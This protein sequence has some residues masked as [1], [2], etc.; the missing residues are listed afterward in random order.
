MARENKRGY[1]NAPNKD[2]P[3]NDRDPGEIAA[4]AVEQLRAYQERAAN[5]PVAR[6]THGKEHDAGWC[7]TVCNP[8][9]TLWFINDPS[10]GIYSYTVEEIQTLK[11]AHIR[12]VH[13]G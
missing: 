12:Q 7:C 5:W 4:V 3:L 1:Y 11:V 9:Q 2:I 13:S 6:H 8:C 10:G